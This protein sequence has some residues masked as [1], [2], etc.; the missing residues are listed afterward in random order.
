MAEFVEGS[1]RFEVRGTAADH[2]AWLRTR[3]ALERTV[4]SW[5]RTAV[6]ADI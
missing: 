3:F 6:L 5:V 1:P 4:M 2:F